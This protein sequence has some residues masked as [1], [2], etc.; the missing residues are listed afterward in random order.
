MPTIAFYTNV[1]IVGVLS[2]PE[3]RGLKRGVWVKS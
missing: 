1:G 2:P 3:G